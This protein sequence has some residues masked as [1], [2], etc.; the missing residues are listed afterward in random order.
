MIIIICCYSLDSIVAADSII[1]FFN[2]RIAYTKPLKL[3]YYSTKI[4]LLI[5]EGIQY[6]NS[7]IILHTNHMK[8]FLCMILSII[9]ILNH[10]YF[11]NLT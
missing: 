6:Q 1:F 8:S 9:F 2:F 4:H 7:F 10:F 3:K 5:L 11:F